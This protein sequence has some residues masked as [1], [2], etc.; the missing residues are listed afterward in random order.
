M[1]TFGKR[2]QSMQVNKNG[3]I[4]MLSK[5][6]KAGY[7]DGF[8]RGSSF[9]TVFDR[10]EYFENYIRKTNNRLFGPEMQ[11][12]RKVKNNATFIVQSKNTQEDFNQKVKRHLDNIMNEDQDKN[13]MDTFSPRDEGDKL[14][15]INQG[16]KDQIAGLQDTPPDA[17]NTHK[18]KALKPL[19]DIPNYMKP[20]AAW[21]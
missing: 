9:A 19:K 14:P 2:S 6:P 7:Q 16:T 5:T 1:D 4:S 3:P 13:F 10:R 12:R 17:K 15:S 21:L 11:Q 8:Q 20:N 18:I